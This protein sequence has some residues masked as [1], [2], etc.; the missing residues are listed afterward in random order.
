MKNAL[1]AINTWFDFYPTQI[2]DFTRGLEICPMLFL[3][4]SDALG[5]ADRMTE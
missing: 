1:P 3:D 5:R 4:V 2:K